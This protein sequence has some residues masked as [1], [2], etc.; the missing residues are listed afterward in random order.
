[1]N[2]LTDLELEFLIGCCIS[3]KNCKQ[4]DKNQ[5]ELARIIQE[6]LGNYVS[7]RKLIKFCY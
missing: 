5:R 3:I 1:M 4:V 7:Q 2:D 6:K